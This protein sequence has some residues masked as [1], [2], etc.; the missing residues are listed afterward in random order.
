MISA[1]MCAWFT[2]VSFVA[3]NLSVLILLSK[4]G[5]H[6]VAS[7]VRAELEPLLTNDGESIAHYA[8]VAQDAAIAA[9]EAAIEAKDA[10]IEVKEIIQQKF[11]PIV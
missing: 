2:V 4:Y 9:K 8:H 10:A 5:R 6:W 1:I 11:G 7:M 3:G